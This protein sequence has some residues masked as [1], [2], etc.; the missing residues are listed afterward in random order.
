MIRTIKTYVD[1][2]KEFLKFIEISNNLFNRYVEWSFQVNSYNKNKAHKELYAQLREEYSNIPS[3]LIQSIRDNALEAVKR[4]KFKFKPVKKPY[5]AIR[6]DSR[7]ITY[8]KKLDKLTNKEITNLT[9]SWF[10][11]LNR[12]KTIV[13]IPKFFTD[14]YSDLYFSAATIGYDKFKNKFVINLIFKD[15]SLKKKKRKRTVE[16]KLEFYKKQAELKAL[17][18]AEKLKNKDKPKVKKEKK[19]VKNNSIIS[20]EDKKLLGIDRGIYNIITTSDGFKYVANKIRAMRRKI[21]R[22]KRQLQKKGTRSAKRKLVKLSG[23]EKRFILNINHI[24][25]KMIASLPYDIFILEDLTGI[26]NK[27]R[28]GK[29]LNKWLSNW[30]FYQLEYLLKYKAEALGK[31][32]VYVDPRNTSVKCSECGCINKKNRKG[33]H[34]HC[35]RCG[36]SD[37]ADK[38]AAKN[39]RNDYIIFAVSEMKKAEQATSQLAECFESAD[40]TV[41]LVSSHQPCAGG[42]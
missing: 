7:T 16:E 5:S 29:K 8:F 27:K 21:L 25:S 10:S 26:R 6:Y 22:L 33:S 41:D 15:S 32:V 17:K 9:L 14:R 13:N 35:D 12:I 30:S 11:D 24:I 42:N 20:I 40:K 4:D 18:V 31:T 37:H 2:P 39:I 28:K 38:N 1:L 34:F 19:K 3:A 23:Y 36:Y